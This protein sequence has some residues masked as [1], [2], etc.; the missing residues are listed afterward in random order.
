MSE[1]SLLT[2]VFAEIK[3]IGKRVHKLNLAA[4][5][6]DARNVITAQK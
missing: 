3:D 6:C 1:R 2:R 5:Y 4:K